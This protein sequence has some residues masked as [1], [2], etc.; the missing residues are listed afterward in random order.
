M[1]IPHRSAEGT[2]G[3]PP[4]GAYFTINHQILNRSS[5]EPDPSLWFSREA[6][7][8]PPTLSDGTPMCFGVIKEWWSGAPSPQITSKIQRRIIYMG[9]D[10]PPLRISICAL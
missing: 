5:P 2:S 7:E 4:D 1:S 10:P 3:R 9:G 8:T 6:G